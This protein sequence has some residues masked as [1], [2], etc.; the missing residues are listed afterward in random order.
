MLLAIFAPWA[1]NAQNTITLSDNVTQTI[2]PNTTYNFYDSGGPSSDY[3]CDQNYTATLTCV[4]DI[5]INFSQFV[6]ESSSYCSDWDH[7]HIYDGDASTGT[8]LARGQTDCYS[9]TLTTGVDY[10]ASSG[11]MTIVWKSDGSDVAAGWAATITGG[12]APA[13]PKPS[14]F[15]ASNVTAH[16]ANLSWES[17]GFAFLLQYKKASDSDWTQRWLDWDENPYELT[18]L[19]GETEYQA[20]VAAFHETCPTDPETGDN[21][22]S[23]WRE[24]SFTTLATC[25]PVTNIT[26]SDIT[27]TGAKLAWDGP[28]GATSWQYLTL[29]HGATPDWTSERVITSISNTDVPA[30]IY[31][32]T[33]EQP[34]PNTEY[35]FY[36][37]ANCGDDDYSEAAMLTFRTACGIITIDATHQWSEGFEEYNEG[38]SASSGAAVTD[39]EC[40]ERVLV[41][42]STQSPFVYRNYQEAASTGLA[43]LELKTGT[44]PVMVALPEFS[45]RIQDLHVAFNYN[46]TS[47]SYTYTAEL[48]YISDVADATTFVKLFDIPTPI[49]RGSH[50]TFSQDLYEAAAAAN[51]PEGSRVAIRFA[52][53]HQ[54]PTNPPSWNFDDFVVSYVSDCR[55]PTGLAIASGYPTAHGVAFTWDYEANEVF[56]FALPLD[57]VTDPTQVN[58]NTTWYAGEDFPIWTNLTADQDRIFWLRKKCSDDEYSDPVS[59][60]FHTLEACPAPTGFAVAPNGLTGHTATLTWTGTSDEYQVRYQT[61]AYVNGDEESFGTNSIPSGWENKIGLLSSVMTG[62]ELT[63]GSQWYFGT[64]NGVFDSHARI[65]IYGGGSNERKGWLITPKFTLPAGA[66]LSFDLALTAYSGTVVAP[67]T[68]G[69]DD[70]FVVLITTDNE[71]TWTILRQ[72][73]ND[74]ATTGASYAVYNDITCSATG[75]QVIIDLSTYAGQDVRIAFYGEST[76][77]NADNHLHIDNV[78]IGTPVPA[79]E[80]QYASNITEQTVTLEGLLAERKYNAWLQGDC[81]SE[82]LSTE[83]GPFTFTTTIACPAPTA[84][85]KV[86]GTL[87]SDRVNLSW[88]NGGSENW[89][90]AYKKTADENFTEL[91]VATTNVTIEGTTVTYT[92]TGLDETTEYTVKVRD[93][94]EPTYTGD[95]QSAWTSTVSF[96]TMPSC[97]VAN[98]TVNDITHHAANVRWDGESASGFTVKYRTAEQV[99]GIDEQFSGSSLP[100]GWELYSGMVNDVIAGTATLST[101]TS[102]WKMV[103]ASG[104]V[105]SSNHVKINVYGETVHYWLVSPTVTLTANSVL[106]FDL[107]LTAYLPDG[108]NTDPVDGT[109]D[110]DRFV[111]LIYADNAWHILRE[112]N[113]TDSEYVYNNIATAGATISGINL[114][115][116]YGKTVKIAFYGESTISGNGDNDIHIDNV[117]FGTPA[118]AGTEIDVPATDS[119]ANLENLQAGKKYEVKVVPN[120][121]ETLASDWVQFNTASANEKWFITEGNWGTASNWEPTGAPTIEQNVT[122]LANATIES[123]CVA[124]AKSIAGTGTGNNAYTLTIKDGGQ[125]I[126]SNVGVTATVE[127]NISHWTVPSDEGTTG[128]WHFI[129]PPINT[130]HLQASSVDGLITDNLGNDATPE[131]GTYD[132]YSFVQNPTLDEN[133]VGNEWKNYRKNMFELDD[134]TGYLYASKEGTILK[135]TGNINALPIT[136]S[137]AVNLSYASESTTED[138]TCRGWN[139]VGNPFTFNTYVNMSYY[140][141]NESGSA[142][143]PVDA[144]QETTIAPC[145]GIMVQATETGQSITFSKN[146]PENATPSNGNLNIALAQAN[147]RNN[148]VM[149]KA[150]LSFNEGSQLSKFYFGQSKA[151]IYFPQFNEELAI[152]Y[153]EGAGEMPLSFRAKENGT[154]TLSFSSENTEFNYLHLIDNMTGTDIDLLQTPSYTFDAHTTDYT[155]RFKL[156]FVC[157]DANAD[158]DSFA[159]YSNGNWI[160]SNEGE[161]TLQVIDVNGRILSSESVNGS[162]SKAVNAAAGVYVLRLINGNDVKVQK[163]IIK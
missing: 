128:G 10:V 97:S 87:Q 71:T 122:L 93:N 58:F 54:L 28:N 4:G 142:I 134:G 9:A 96:T 125:L 18:G 154:Y 35:D 85:Q 48:G 117:A 30:N 147:V 161:A 52:S 152:A 129:A 90:V 60:T 113:N 67:A 63:S 115:E 108:S 137:Q 123:G 135:F 151:N 158:S 146:R 148:A 64:N 73:D 88:T 157:G 21:V 160:I 76:Q 46:C 144:Y 112:W 41:N 124:E 120:C 19:T 133:G 94:C 79:G 5:T 132:L 136:A 153:S 78:A 24:I 111:V 17:E 56:Q 68:N 15:V 36:V 155:S 53:G 50:S 140:K 12:E 118:Y 13:C 103:T 84:L 22:H 145:T 159:F 11:T 119:P 8:L 20:R 74:E 116:Y 33:G 38:T 141:M 14:N 105:F 25:M 39:I 27:S 43:S 65:N 89:I 162:V 139:L 32:C 99:D 104:N 1:A 126:H 40:W 106:S 66:A 131:T 3:G 80:M 83:V 7:M 62:T 149:D 143:E 37:R 61:T 29:A 70:K 101:T 150:I 75:E 34:Q 102:G 69:T 107:A 55:K 82:G 127:K 49:E 59:I 51:A 6:T 42:S 86:E 110:D 95:G 45:A 2:A 57:M 81:G 16:T 98:V 114:S 121:D 92:L 47:T 100:S 109:C 138:M 156:V 72:W 23:D 163:V 26:V 44:S 91:N 31:A 77:S 130:P